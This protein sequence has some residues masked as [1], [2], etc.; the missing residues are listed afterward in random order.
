MFGMLLIIVIQ[1]Q[2]NYIEL[3]R[4]HTL[5]THC[6]I[7]RFTFV[8]GYNFA[9]FRKIVEMLLSCIGGPSDKSTHCTQT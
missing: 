7:Y 2:N 4:A 1:V 5:C 8:H 6:A 9:N 3:C